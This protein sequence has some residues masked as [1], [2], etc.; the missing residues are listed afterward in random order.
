[1]R[2]TKIFLVIGLLGY[3]VIGLTG[4][5]SLKE[6]AVETA[7][8]AAEAIKGAIGISTKEVEEARPSAIKK[9]VNLGYNECYRKSLKVLAIIGAYVYA[10]D[11]KKKMIAFYLS[12]ED[13]TVAGVFLKE[14]DASTTEVEVVSPSTFA[15]ELIAGKFFWRLD[16]S[17]AEL[18]KIAAAEKKEK[19]EKEKKEK[20]SE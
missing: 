14:I 15:K 13:T 7:K 5:A 6:G 9:T 10:K 8:G 12:E 3:W 17:D 1:M 11:S 16:K 2:T 19:E 18:E 20:K 4:C